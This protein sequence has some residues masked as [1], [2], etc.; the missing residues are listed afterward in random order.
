MGLVASQAPISVFLTLTA[1]VRDEM[2][3]DVPDALIPGCAVCAKPLPVVF[4][5][6]RCRVKQYCGTACQAA[7]WPSH[8]LECV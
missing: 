4:K 3:M 7:D 8:K 2:H 6:S 1:D 5:C